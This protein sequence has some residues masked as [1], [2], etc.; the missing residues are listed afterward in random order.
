MAYLNLLL[1]L[2]DFILSISLRIAH[3]LAYL[4]NRET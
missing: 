3:A 4:L 2:E 1:D